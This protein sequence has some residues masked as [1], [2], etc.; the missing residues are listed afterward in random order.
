MSILCTIL[1]LASCLILTACSDEDEKARLLEGIVTR[2]ALNDSLKKE[3]IQSEIDK[4]A[5][6]AIS[7]SLSKF[8]DLLL[9]KNNQ[10]H[11]ELEQTKQEADKSRRDNERLQE[12]IGQLQEEIDLLQED[13]RT[14]EQEIH[15]LAVAIDSISVDQDRLIGVN[16]DLQNKLSEIREALNAVH[17]VQKSVRLLV[18][19]ESRLKSNHFLKTSRGATLRKQYKLV[20][21]IEGDDPRVKIVPINQQLPLTLDSIP[22]ALVGRPGKLKLKALADRHGKLKEGRDYTV[23]KSKGTTVITFI[24]RVLEGTDVLAV[25]EV[26]N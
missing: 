8:G 6:E 16:Q 17:R 23:R 19:T 2:S 10:L 22:T 15:R 26:E 13:K 21:K 12:E 7:D 4:D 14:N 20:E 24:N 11:K 1:A 9:E 25:V 18:G 3:I 5:L